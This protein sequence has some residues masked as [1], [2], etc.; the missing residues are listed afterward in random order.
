MYRYILPINHIYSPFVVIKRSSETEKYPIYQL[1]HHP[2]TTF[3]LSG[4][5]GS[6]R[7]RRERGNPGYTESSY[8][9]ADSA[10]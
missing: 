8:A 1:Y 4:L 6:R 10:G 9:P 5:S 7:D 2:T 3:I